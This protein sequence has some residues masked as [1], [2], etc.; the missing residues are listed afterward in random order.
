MVRF[1]AKK[2]E[3]FLLF[4]FTKKGAKSPIIF[5]TAVMI[6]IWLLQSDLRPFPN[7][8]H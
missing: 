1:G 4:Y 3:S 7:Q 2:E 6:F 8:L 5:L